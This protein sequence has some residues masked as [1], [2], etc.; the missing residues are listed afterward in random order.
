MTS[1]EILQKPFTFIRHGQTTW[2]ERNLCQGQCDTPLSPSGATSLSQLGKTL[3]PSLYQ[4]LAVSPLKRALDTAH[5]LLPFLPAARL[6]VIPQL[7]ERYFGALQGRPSKE[8]Y[9]FEKD[10]KPSTAKTLHIE[11]K[12]DF[13]LRIIEGMNQALATQALGVL[14]VSHGRV[15]KALTEILRCDPCHQIDNASLMTFTFKNSR[16]S[17]TKR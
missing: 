7:R 12:K 17:Y 5:L 11:P 1:L 3:T 10:E 14:I 15:C 4:L 9:A 13:F 16:W 2:N 6:L 8:M